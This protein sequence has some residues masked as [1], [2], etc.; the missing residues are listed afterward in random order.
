M[1]GEEIPYIASAAGARTRSEGGTPGF[2]AARTKLSRFQRAAAGFGGA[3]RCSPR[4]SRAGARASRGR[5]LRHT[6][7]DRASS[8][9]HRPGGMRPRRR[10]ADR[11]GAGTNRQHVARA[12]RQGACALER[13]AELGVESVRDGCAQRLRWQ[14]APD[15]AQNKFTRECRLGVAWKIIV[16]FLES[17]E[18]EADFT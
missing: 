16:R 1:S 17:E 2:R 5:S 9:P 6:A 14:T 15:T 18:T 12:G 3:P 8:G 7:G 10:V 11:G 13:V 4:G